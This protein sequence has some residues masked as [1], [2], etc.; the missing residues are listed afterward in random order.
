MGGRRA[1]IVMPRLSGFSRGQKIIK[2]S[3]DLLQNLFPR[4]SDT[5]AALH[6]RHGMFRKVLWHAATFLEGILLSA[7]GR[8]LRCAWPPR[9]I[10]LPDRVS[11]IAQQQR[12]ARDRA[13]PHRPV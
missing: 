1:E 11:R 7:K 6:H 3:T 5:H 9:L 10:T 12:I 13:I 8:I 2:V 4:L